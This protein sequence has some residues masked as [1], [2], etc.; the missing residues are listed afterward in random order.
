MRFA[1]SLAPMHADEHGLKRDITEKLIVLRDE[2][3][4]EQ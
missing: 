3:V 1:T 2:E 4:S